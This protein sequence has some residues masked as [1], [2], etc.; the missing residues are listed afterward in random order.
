MDQNSPT[1][2]QLLYIYSLI[3]PEMLNVFHVFDLRIN[4]S[5]YYVRVLI[6]SST[7]SS[8]PLILPRSLW[9]YFAFDP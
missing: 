3:V 8:I 6:P 7:P 2:T 9:R 5:H 1:S 4:E